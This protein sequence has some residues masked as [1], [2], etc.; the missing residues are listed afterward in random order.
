VKKIAKIAEDISRESQ[1]TLALIIDE[2]Q[3]TGADPILV[4][5]VSGIHQGNI[6]LL[7]S[8]NDAISKKSYATMAIRILAEKPLIQATVFTTL[9]EAVAA[10]D[11]VLHRRT[12]RNKAFIKR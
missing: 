3:K 1:G 4:R 7:C 8:H 11:Q 6:V 12:M 5:I 2:F 9:H 10:R